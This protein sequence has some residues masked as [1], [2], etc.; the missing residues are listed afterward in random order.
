MKKG[1][2]V[3]GRSFEGVFVGNLLQTS[4]DELHYYMRTDNGRCVAF[5]KKYETVK[6]VNRITWSGREV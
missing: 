6:P 1:D 5:S 3:G 4:P 2:R